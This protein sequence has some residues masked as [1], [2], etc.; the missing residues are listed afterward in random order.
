MSSPNERKQNQEF[1]RRQQREQR[2]GRTCCIMNSVEMMQG[3]L[4]ALSRRVERLEELARARAA[5]SS[6]VAEAQKVAQLV[7]FPVEILVLP[8]RIEERRRLAREL[9]SRGWSAARIARV[10]KCGERAVAFW[11]S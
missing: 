2:D 1:N 8:K 4:A 7:G 10:M 6:D 11:L 9:R 5:G 3:Q